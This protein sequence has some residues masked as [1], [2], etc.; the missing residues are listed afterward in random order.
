VTVAIVLL[1]VLWISVF[2]AVSIDLGARKRRLPM[3]TIGLCV[4][5]A[6]CLLAQLSDPRLLDAFERDAAKIFAGQWWRILTALFFQD[7]RLAGGLSNISF[8]LLIGGLAEQFLRRGAWLVIYWLGALVA[9]GVAL[10]WQ[11]VGAGSSVGICTLAGAMIVMR[12]AGSTRA[13][14]AALR[15]LAGVLACVLIALRDIHGAATVAGAASTLGL[16]A[17]RQDVR[18]PYQARDVD[19]L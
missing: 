2:L 16:L 10:S 13:L 12:P 7:G 18:A 1:L 8:L 11:P 14:P 5:L 19:A 6:L 4:V 15:M 17:L 9:E 3:L